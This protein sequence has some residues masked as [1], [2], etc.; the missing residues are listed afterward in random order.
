MQ[1]NRSTVQKE[2]QCEYGAD[3]VTPWSQEDQ[4]KPHPKGKPSLVK[5]RLA[6]LSHMPTALVNLK[7]S[8]TEKET[9]LVERLHSEEFSQLGGLWLGTTLKGNLLSKIELRL[10]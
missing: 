4:Q 9:P 3:H 10:E 1:R 2:S 7:S 6:V 5:K 8:L